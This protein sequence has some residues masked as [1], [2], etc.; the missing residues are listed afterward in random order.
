MP[1][2]PPSTH[3]F[4]TPLSC[5]DDSFSLHNFSHYVIARTPDSF[6]GFA[7]T[8]A[9]SPTS[10]SSPSSLSSAS[11][12]VA[13]P[14]T[15]CL[16]RVI[17]ALF[18]LCLLPSQCGAWSSSFLPGVR[19][20]TTSWRASD[21]SRTLCMKIQW[22]PYTGQFIDLGDDAGEIG[23]PSRTPSSSASS[24]PGEEPNK[25][26]GLKAE[27]LKGVGG[28]V[29]KVNAYIAQKLM[30]SPIE[31]SPV[32]VDALLQDLEDLGLAEGEEATWPEITESMQSVLRNEQ[33]AALETVRRNVDLTRATTI[34]IHSKDS[35][36][37]PVLRDALKARGG[38]SRSVTVGERGGG[39]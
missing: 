20:R 1:D 17:T 14:C 32:K 15:M 34:L 26:T 16:L 38:A 23:V 6:S 24:G 10:F 4:A 35:G 29:G 37:A 36:L 11:S 5:F 7:P 21:I 2:L 30:E 8:S 33:A 28:S 22:D 9:M 25:A 31:E 18:I 39:F 3:A 19:S 27:D 13:L 12:L